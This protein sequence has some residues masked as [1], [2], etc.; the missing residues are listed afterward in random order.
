MAFYKHR[1]SQSLQTIDIMLAAV[2]IWFM[3]TYFDAHIAYN[4]VIA[5]RLVAV[6]QIQTLAL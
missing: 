1:G 3:V 5:L 6:L 2:S 4:V